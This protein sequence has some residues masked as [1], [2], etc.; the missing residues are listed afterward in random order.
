MDEQILQFYLDALQRVS[1]FSG[2]DDVTKEFESALQRMEAIQ[3]DTATYRLLLEKFRTNVAVP[4]ETS[5][6]DTVRLLQKTARATRRHRE[7]LQVDPESMKERYRA[8]INKVFPE[9]EPE[10]AQRD[11]EPEPEPPKKGRKGRLDFSGLF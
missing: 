10:Q 9:P 8:V 4:A 2:D 1:R 3:P 11:G 6:A 5:E 7:E